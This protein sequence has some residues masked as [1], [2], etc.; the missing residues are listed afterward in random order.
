MAIRIQPQPIESISTSCCSSRAAL[1][2]CSQALHS[3]I[4]EEA[5][6]VRSLRLMP[7]SDPEAMNQHR[8]IERC[9]ERYKVFLEYNSSRS[10]K[11]ATKTPIPIELQLI[12]KDIIDNLVISSFCLDERREFTICTYY[13]NYVKDIP[14]YLLRTKK[15]YPL[16]MCVKKLP[17]G[18]LR[19]IINEI[20]IA[21]PRA[22]F[23]KQ[24]ILECL[25]DSIK[26]NKPENVKFLLD[27]QTILKLQIGDPRLNSPSDTVFIDS[28]TMNEMCQCGLCSFFIDDKKWQQYIIDKFGEKPITDENCLKNFLGL[29]KSGNVEILDMF[30]D[31]FL[32]ILQGELNE[33]KRDIFSAAVGSGSPDMINYVCKNFGIRPEKYLNR[34]QRFSLRHFQNR[35]NR[36]IAH[37]YLEDLTDLPIFE[38]VSNDSL[39]YETTKFMIQQQLEKNV[40]LS[41]VNFYRQN[42][43]HAAAKNKNPEVMAY[44]INLLRNPLALKAR[45]KNNQTALEIAAKYDNLSVVKC[46]IENA[47]WTKEELAEALYFAVVNNN[48]KMAVLLCS[49]GAKLNHELSSQKTTILHVAALHNRVQISHFLLEQGGFDI[50]AKREVTSTRFEETALDAVAIWG[51]V[52]LAKLFISK[53]ATISSRTLRHA[54]DGGSLELVQELVRRKASYAELDFRIGFYSKEIED[55][56]VDTPIKKALLSGDLASVKRHVSS[57]NKITP[58]EFHLAV[59]SENRELMQYL[60]ANGA[61]ADDVDRGNYVED[62]KI[63][64][65]EQRNLYKRK[66]RCYYLSLFTTIISAVGAVVASACYFNNRN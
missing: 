31:K 46:L 30:K 36:T 63:F 39:N 49:K 17:D 6:S 53:G 12:P 14:Y 58:N 37:T 61:W 55:F 50:N 27:P 2:S 9:F 4:S 1:S 26:L 57:G 48:I 24:Q 20:V 13:S 15:S 11:D 8:S 23:S 47:V 43:F 18:S 54:A 66:N 10:R 28:L 16:S 21:N 41:Q 56:L 59:K 7:P 38:L 35:E 19:E 29:I 40:N 45:D 62:D 33:R 42:I 44:L 22:I 3:G 65:N 52:S 25:Y 5:P 51:N 32:L 34:N 60:I 64:L